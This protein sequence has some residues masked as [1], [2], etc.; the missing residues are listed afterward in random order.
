MAL[1][2]GTSGVRGLV[3]EMTDLECAF[4]TRAFVLYLKAAGY[5]AA[6]TL[7]GDFRSS[8]PGILRAVAFA[9]EDEGLAVDF[10]GFIPTPALAAYSL[11]R[12]EAGIMVTGSHIP[13]DR[14]G[15]KFYMPSGEVLKRDE[16]EISRLYERL[17]KQPAPAGIFSNEGG[18]KQEFVPQLGAVNVRVEESYKERYLNFFKHGALAGLKLVVY[19]HS[20]VAR[21]IL[22]EILAGLGADVIRVGRSESFVPVDTEAVEEPERLAK[23]V[24]D[25]SADALLT[26]DGDGDRP[27][28]VDERGRVVRGDILGILVAEYLVADS[29]STPVNSNTALEKCGSFDFIERT[30]IGSPHV[31]ASMFKAVGSG[32]KR[33]VGYEANG[34]FLTASPMTNPET[35]AELLSLPT[36]DA[37]LPLIAA[38]LL[39]KERGTSLSKLI[40]GLPTRFTCSGIIRNFPSELGRAVAD[41]FEKE[42]R[43]HADKYFAAVFGA[44]AS[45]DFTD[46]ARITFAGG[47]IVHLRPSGNAPEFRC[48]TE[49]STEEEAEENNRKAIE[50]IR[51]VLRAAAEA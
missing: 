7:A 26:A 16:R 48:Y 31:I 41:K 3:T 2:F 50:I 33:V 42:G 34:G 11:K 17:K 44:A 8:T 29:I 38:L 36:R 47:N 21:D 20:S 45:L 46:G 23:W 32:Y 37:A 13:D 39:A 24:A 35:G 4:Y 15:I 14:N 5:S 43:L 27:L 51:T 30:K 1:K 28:L 40:A 12:A 19:E 6:V 49:S 18:L 25:Y 10:C 9:I 22:P